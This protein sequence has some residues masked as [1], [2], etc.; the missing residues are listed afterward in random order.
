MYLLEKDKKRPTIS[1]WK[2][3]FKV[4][5]KK[6][7]VFFLTLLVLFIGSFSFLVLKFYF[8]NT[9]I[10]PAQ[11]GI[12]IEGVIGQPRFIN[13][14][15]ANSD[16]DRDLVELTFSGLMKYNE[17]MEIIPDLVQNYEIENNGKSY[18]FYLKENLLW[19]DKTPLTANDVIFTI[20]TIQNPEYKSPFRANWIGVEVEKVNDLIVKFKLKKPYSAFL[21]NCT[22]K[23]LPK[24]I[25]Q[26]ISS[27]SFAFEPHNLEPIGSG[28]YKF[29]ELKQEKTE[30]INYITLEQNPLYL[31]QQP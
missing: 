7:K 15:Y 3:F 13:P 5:T 28:L 26:E 1:Q 23:I 20:K 10:E 8:Q 19:Q 29:K 16:I 14:I 2:Q 18:I 27:E 24:H 30:Y 25:W 22:V 9:R 31:E 12:H 17:N 21:E 4:L 6:E 11:G